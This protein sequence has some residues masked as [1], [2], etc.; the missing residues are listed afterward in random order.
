MAK[1]IPIIL[2]AAEIAVGAF[3]FAS[4]FATLTPLSA[5]LIESGAGMVLA[6]LGT[7]LTPGALQG[8][9]VLSRNPTAP[10]NVIYGQAKTGGTL[11]HIYEFGDNDKYLDMVSV[12]NCHSSKSVD[13]L[14]FDGQRVALDANGCSFKPFQQTINLVS[15]TRSNGVVVAVLSHSI[16]DL[17]TGD[18]LQLQNIWDK[19][20]N[21]KYS[22][23]VIDSFSFSY[24]C[25]GSATT[26]LNSGQVLTVWPD[27]GAKIHMEVLL[28]NH[29][30]TFPG[31]INGTPN[32]G[33]TDDLIQNIYNPWTYAHRLLGKTC[34]FLR[35]HYNDTIFANGLPTI[36][37]RL[38]GKNDIYDPRLGAATTITQPNVK[39]R[40]TTTLNGW[41][42]NAHV[43]PYELGVDQATQW[44]L[45]DDTTFAYANADTAVDGDLTSAAQSRFQHNHE[46][47]G[48]IWSFA[49]LPAETLWLNVYSEVPT[50]SAL[51]I[52]TQR[53]AGIWYTLNGGTTWTMLYDSAS[54]PLAWDNVPLSP[55]QDMSQVQVMAFNDSHDDMVHNV[56]DVNV[57]D[58]PFLNSLADPTKVY[59]DN[60]ALCIA[61]FLNQPTWGFKAAYGTEVPLPQLI[62]AANICDETVALADGSTEL[63]YAC[64]GEF[65][66]NMKRGDILQNMLTSC[67]GRLVYSGGIFVIHPAAWEG[68]G[69]SIGT[70]SSPNLIINGGFEAG[71]FTGWTVSSPPHT[72]CSVET[73]Q[74]H[75]GTYA[76]LLS[77]EYP[78]TGSNNSTGGIFQ[79][80]TIPAGAVSPVLKFWYWPAIGA[81]VPV[82]NVLTVSIADPTAGTVTQVLNSQSNSQTWTSVS[83][84]MS[85]FIGH[86]V[87]LTFGITLSS[88]ALGVSF[89]YLDDVS[90][91]YTMA[92]VHG[93]ATGLEIA[94]G[95]FR[96]REK[97]SVRNLYNGVKGTF[98]SP[99]NTWQTA[100]IPAY[101][102]DEDHGYLSGS[103]LF[104]LGDANMAADGGD[105]RWLDVQLPFTISVA[106]AQRLCKIELMRRR[107][108]GTGTFSYN[109]AMY[110]ATSLD[111]A[112]MT[113]PILGWNQKLL[114]VTSHRFTMTK[115]QIDGI[116]ATLLGTELD[117]QATDPSV[118]DW[119]SSEELTAQGNPQTFSG[120]GSGS[121]LISFTNYTN[122]PA[123]ALTQTDATHIAIAAVSVEFAN[124]TIHYGPRVVAIADPGSV[125]TWYYVTINDPD[126]LGDE[127]GSTPTAY[128]DLTTTNVGLNGFIYIGAIL[129]TH[130]AGLVTALPGGW[131]APQS[132]LVSG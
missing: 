98:I 24:I 32:D 130:A 20:F 104:P 42:N 50:T 106:A 54:H 49:G 36:A 55:T 126:F 5:F 56:F 113:L 69:L 26:V 21:G 8:T 94:T 39:G 13:A 31:M 14:L 35:L 80:V 48:C 91:T 10:W 60:A 62:S 129:C 27:Y 118:Y 83:F 51:N 73:A 112:Q 78:L 79:V 37:F 33:D 121:N 40:P 109:M 15:V 23:T 71:N 127:T 17:Q 12:L 115:Q 85:R 76:A 100:D 9:S 34:V 89:M 19:T 75:L 86:T 57:A 68:V 3:I 114:E 18:S 74:V 102:Q 7:L 16:I 65:K 87:Y 111:I 90:I 30:E 61:D 95:G 131:P 52:V 101:A 72:P 38:S 96:W 107:Q 99:A 28:G 22:V 105:R 125:P 81:T 41:G 45:N 124:S 2:G 88:A 4:S 58:G 77:T 59:T 66:L 70:T 93:D 119:S 108:Q 6:G 43:G 11:V 120:N 128:A 103:P 63:R 123:V 82:V 116:D 1:Y 47:A 46:Y 97:V 25:G 64:N 29:T 132:F 110:Q 117:F 67:G 122:L 53:S 92:G 44:G 84:D